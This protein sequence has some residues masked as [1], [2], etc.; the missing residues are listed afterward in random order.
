MY[1]VYLYD[2]YVIMMIY[3]VLV[4]IKLTPSKHEVSCISTYVMLHLGAHQN[5]TCFVNLYQGTSQFGENNLYQMKYTTPVH[6]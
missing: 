1:L 2:M 4:L 5:F 3:I 6:D